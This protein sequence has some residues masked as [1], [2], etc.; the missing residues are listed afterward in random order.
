MTAFENKSDKQQ[1]FSEIR[2]VVT[3]LNDGEKFCSI[4]IKAGHQNKRD[5][6]LVC[7]KAQYDQIMKNA[8][9]SIDDKVLVRYFIS[10]RKKTRWYTAANILDVQK[11]NFPD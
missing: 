3:E 7:K 10:S 6:N 2:G 5:V 1:F 8:S 4:T 11:I 9:I